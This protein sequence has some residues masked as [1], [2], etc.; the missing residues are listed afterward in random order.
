MGA[1]EKENYV[2]IKEGKKWL[3]QMLKAPKL[4]GE[5]ESK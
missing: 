2:Y 5:R 4:K 3:S 1:K